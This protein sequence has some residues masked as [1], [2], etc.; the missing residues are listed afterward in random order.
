[1][2]ARLARLARPAASASHNL[3][4]CISSLTSTFA[5]ATL[6]TAVCYFASMALGSSSVGWVHVI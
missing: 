1:M 4:G 5:C 2:F 6:S 3:S